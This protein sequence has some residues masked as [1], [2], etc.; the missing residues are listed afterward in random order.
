MPNDTDHAIRLERLERIE[1]FLDSRFPEWNNTKP[2]PA[3]HPLAGLE[4][5]HL[6]AKEDPSF[7]EYWYSPE[8]CTIEFLLEGYAIRAWR[9]S[10]THAPVPLWQV[11]KRLGVEHPLAGLEY[12]DEEM[13]T[14][15]WIACDS[16]SA[17]IADYR[18]YKFRD[19][20]THA[21]VPLWEVAKRLG[22][23]H[24]AP[25]FR[26]GD[27]VEVVEPMRPWFEAGERFV[28]HLVDGEYIIRRDKM[29]I[30]SEQVRLISRP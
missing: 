11:A 2:T 9:D 22:K 28:V 4:Y 24:P 16:K 29:M 14:Y 25:G 23:E 15:S 13:G 8:P 1:N 10:T 12:E 27:L 19:S 5:Q 17:M 3:P 26:I 7:A 20:T 18:P 6:D 21:P 30:A